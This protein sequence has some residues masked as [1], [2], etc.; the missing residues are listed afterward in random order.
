MATPSGFNEFTSDYDKVNRI[1]V[2]SFSKRKVY[3]KAFWIVY[4]NKNFTIRLGETKPTFSCFLKTAGEQFGDPITPLDIEQYTVMFSC[5]DANENMII[6]DVAQI[7][8]AAIGEISYQFKSLDFPKKG[9]Y[10]AE[11]EFTIAGDSFTLPGTNQR[12]EIIVG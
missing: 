4:P 12:I 1:D 6:R 3:D 7:T 9:R 11:I 10:F 5:M 8:N 2:D